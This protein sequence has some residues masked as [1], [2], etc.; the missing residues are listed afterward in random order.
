VSFT[1][2]HPKTKKRVTIRSDTPVE[3][4]AA[5]NMNEV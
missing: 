4:G 3:F 2:T 5:V 1:F